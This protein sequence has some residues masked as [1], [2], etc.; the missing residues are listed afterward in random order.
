[1]KIP[2]TVLVAVVIASAKIYQKYMEE[3]SKND[4]F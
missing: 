4:P 3:Q 2:A 1:M